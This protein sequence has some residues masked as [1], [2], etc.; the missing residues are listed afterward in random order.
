MESLYM[1][2]ARGNRINV[3]GGISPGDTSGLQ[4]SRDYIAMYVPL[5]EGFNQSSEEV[6]SEGKANTRAVLLPSV[7]IAPKKYRIAVVPNPLLYEYADVFHEPLIEPDSDSQPKIY[8]RFRK[9]MP[10][11]RLEYLVRLYLVS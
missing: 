1:N 7:R 8:C 2:W 9:D 11:D 3:Y 5:G 4:Y 10:L 6:I